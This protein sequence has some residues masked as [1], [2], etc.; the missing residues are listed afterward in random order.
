[1]GA[2][3]GKAG[4]TA[5][6]AMEAPIALVTGYGSD[7]AQVEKT[8]IEDST[9]RGQTMAAEYRDA[10]Y[11]AADNDVAAM[12]KYVTLDWAEANRFSADANHQELLAKRVILPEGL[13]GTLPKNSSGID[14]AV[15]AVG[16]TLLAS[17][18][19]PGMAGLPISLGA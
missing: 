1:M 16:A 9:S 2:L 8:V 19:T 11:K 10:L 15:L 4:S 5:W 18:V 6:G 3:F 13:E 12:K 14:A 7:P 17:P